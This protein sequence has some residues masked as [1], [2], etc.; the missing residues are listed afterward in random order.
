MRFRLEPQMKRFVKRP[1]VL[2]NTFASPGSAHA[3][4]LIELLVVILFVDG[5]SRAT[6]FTRVFRA[7]PLRALEQGGDWMWY[8]PRGQ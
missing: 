3:F 4:T 1:A 7:N 6:D 8:K 5:H 2:A